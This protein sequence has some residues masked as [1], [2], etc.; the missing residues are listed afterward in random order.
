MSLQSR[1]TRIEKAAAD[2][3]AK[4]GRCTCPNCS[5]VFF[6]DDEADAPTTLPEGPV[7][8]D[9]CG[10]EKVVIVLRYMDAP[11]ARGQEG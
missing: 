6:L 3:G 10:G 4:G 9:K 7:I 2:S 8:C 11:D 5:K 1:L